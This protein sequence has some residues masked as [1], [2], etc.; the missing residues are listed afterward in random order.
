M[1]KEAFSTSINYMQVMDEQGNIDQQLLPKDVDDSKILEMY[2]WMSFARQLDA[3]A[4]SLQRQGRAV[5][6]APLVGEEATQIGS[7]MAMGQND[8]FVPNFRQHGVFLVR[9]L[10]LYAIFLYWKGFEEGSVVG[11]DVNALPYI[12]PVSTQLPHATGI[13]LAQKYRK[14]GGA[15]VTYVGDGGTSEG[16]FYE[17]INFAGIMKAPLVMIIENNG[18]AISEP[19]SE[20]TAAQTL[21]QKAVAAGI[22]SIQVDGNDVISV[23][24]ATKDAISKAA[25]G[26]IVIECITY[27]MSMHTTADDPSKYRP[28]ADVEAWKPKDPLLRVRNYLAKKGLWDDAKES[29]LSEEHLKEIDA[30]VDEAEKFKADP[31]SM[32]QNLYSFIPDTLKEEM[33]A[34]AA[35]NFWQ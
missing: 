11:K 34:A 22:P 25:D 33:D 3:K 6:Y 30:A 2:K 10:P 16:N 9:R 28:Q 7:A 29:T 1:I 8:F 27:R 13:A 19:R 15:V 17:A 5:T 32:F 21:A 23:Y 4:L 35:A 24:K 12:V 26:P 31:K 14:T 20:Q 18:W